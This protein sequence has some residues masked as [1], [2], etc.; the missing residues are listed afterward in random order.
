M[1]L[2]RYYVEIKNR[3]TQAWPLWCERKLNWTNPISFLIHVNIIL[4]NIWLIKI[5]LRL[6]VSVVSSQLCRSADFLHACCKVYYRSSGGDKTVQQDWSVHVHLPA[7]PNTCNHG[8]LH[9]TQV[10]RVH[11]LQLSK[12]LYCHLL[13]DVSSIVNL[14]WANAIHE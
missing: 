4:A 9:H 8:N 11:Q 10:C 5:F 3:S 2:V 14:D 6:I 7:Q 12:A 13:A 1:W